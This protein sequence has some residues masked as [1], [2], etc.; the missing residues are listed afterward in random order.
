MTRGERQKDK[1]VKRAG[2]WMKKEGVGRAAGWGDGRRRKRLRVN[3]RKTG[4]D[5]QTG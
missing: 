4:R 2:R 1:K 3:D 5:V